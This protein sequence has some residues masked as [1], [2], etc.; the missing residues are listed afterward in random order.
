[1]ESKR[2][3]RMAGLEPIEEAK[4]A[5]VEAK[6]IDASIRYID[7]ALDDLKAW[8]VFDL[9]LNRSE[10]MKK[11]KLIAKM[12]EELSSIAW[13]TIALDGKDR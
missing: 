11:A 3:I 13:N 4:K 2:M 12:Q 10:Y 5:G 6:K 1:M 9:E 8:M 7:N